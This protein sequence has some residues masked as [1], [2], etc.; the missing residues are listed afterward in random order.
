MKRLR[1]AVVGAGVC[2]VG[3]GWQLAKSGAEVVVYDAGEP[4]REATWAS[5]GMLAAQME[6]RPEEDHLTV[7]GR[8]SQRRWRAFA[9]ELE[10]DSGISVDYRDEGTLFVALD[11]DAASQL[12]FLHEH[13]RQ[14]SLPVESVTGDEAR[15]L[16]PYLSRAVTMGLLSR[17]DH[18]VDARRVAEALLVALSR[19]G[20]FVRAHAPVD[21]IV[22]EGNQATGVVVRGG[23][24]LADAVLL[25]AGAWS[26]GIAGL[27]EGSV[28][29]VRPIRGQV[30]A[31]RQPDPPVLDRVLWAMN[32]R[33]FVYL[34][35]KSAGTILIGATVEEAGFDKSVTAGGVLDLL[36]PAWEALPILHELS[37]VETWSGLRP[38]SRDNAPILGATDID[39]LFMATGHYRNGILYAPVTAQ[40]VSRAILTGEMSDVIEPYRLD[41]FRSARA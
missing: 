37:V 41:R 18:Q 31:V 21:E 35:P 12:R 28:P 8:E 11:R 2:G 38:S 26:A 5:G 40:D 32:A 36:R 7:L 15:E 27:P 9:A 20:G 17:Q 30:I 23:F 4:M 1:V 22:I 25:A 6:L 10:S 3:I 14:L 29:P 24:E 13:Q 34:A 19:A 33:H 16:E 39:A